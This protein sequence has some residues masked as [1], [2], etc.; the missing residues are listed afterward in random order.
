PGVVLAHGLQASAGTWLRPTIE[1]DVR[2]TAPREARLADLR[3]RRRR[4]VGLAHV[5]RR[6]RWRRRRL[7]LR[8]EL[9][10]AVEHTSQVVALDRLLIEQYLHELLHAVVVLGEPS[11]RPQVRLP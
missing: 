7:R 9:V 1:H 2:L 6:G 10:E 5:F 3:L 11:A 4:L 8:R